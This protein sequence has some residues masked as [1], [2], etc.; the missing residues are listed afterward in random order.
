VTSLDA[1]PIAW[2][3]DVL[4]DGYLA[5]T[6]ELGSDPDGEGDVVATLVRHAPDG[7]RQAADPARPAVLYVHGF[8]DYFFQRHI[9]EFFA[10][11]SVAFYALD[12]RKCGRSRRA[13]Q[14]AHFVTDLA[15]YDAELNEALRIARA[16]TGGPVV[17]VG[18]ST[19]GLVLALWLDRLN[20]EPGGAAAA[21]VAGVVFN[22]PWVDLMGPSYYRTVL[23]PIVDV[24]GRWLP[25][26]PL[27][28]KGSDAYSVGLHVDS[29]HGEW[30]YNLEWKPLTGFPARL[31]WLRAI[32][33]AQ[34]LLH[35]GL[36][37]GVP[38]LVL[39]SQNSRFARTWRPEVDVADA[40]VDVQHI[41]RWAGCF[42]NHTV[43]VP[44]QDG[45]HD[46]Y[47]SLE[48]P[49]AAAFAETARWLDWLQ[50]GRPDP[51]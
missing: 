9:A 24:V 32:R 10:A 39:R 28:I 5:H 30:D 19:G 22:A 45:R 15:F 37:I 49:R 20:R 40:V 6:I 44:I 13:G 7:A 12:L 48:Q 47:L 3:P 50:A 35:R 27:P 16:E 4:G 41:Q 8:S 18:H 23:T 26:T 25:R 33:R 11:R 1:S 51:A 38:A 36:D 14:S 34:A 42:G 29:G 21:G 17:L 2:T 43:V 31:G 46:L